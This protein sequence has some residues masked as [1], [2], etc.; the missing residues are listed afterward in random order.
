MIALCPNPY[1]DLELNTTRRA[2]QLLEEAGFDTVVCPVF[3]EEDPSVLPSDL[4]TVSIESVTD[5]CSLAVVIGGDGTILSVARMLRQKAVPLLG[6]NL[7]TK[8]FL[9]T[10]EE[11]E[12]PLIV[13]AARG[14]YRVSRRMMLEATLEREGEAIFSDHA[15]NDV[16]IHGYGECVYLTATCDGD[17]ITA[18]SGDGIILST[19]TGSTGYSM[20]AGGPIV[21][22][23]AEAIILS[24]I[25][26]HMLGARTFV[27]SA[28]RTLTVK[29]EKLH[30]RKAYLSVDGNAVTD[31]CNGDIIVVRRSPH[32]VLMADLGLRSFYEIAYEKLT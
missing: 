28:D 7:G 12:L 19:P 3:A 18:F 15:L 4:Q 21:E 30:G 6:V 25:C 23:S 13:N 16:V 11:E 27:F 31:L 20:S 29:A 8:G 22:P 26:A 1:R 5:K 10:L 9:A 2:K 17:G 14:E 24:P 32:P